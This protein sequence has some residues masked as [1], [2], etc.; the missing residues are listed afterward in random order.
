LRFD[1]ARTRPQRVVIMAVGVK[2]LSRA[3]QLRDRVQIA[4]RRI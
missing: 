1:Q 4:S 2:K 3:T